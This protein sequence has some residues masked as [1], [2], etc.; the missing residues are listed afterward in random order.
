MDTV[1][2]KTYV[3]IPKKKS[4]KQSESLCE[5]KNNLVTQ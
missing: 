5:A 4:P 3:Q 1:N 2:S